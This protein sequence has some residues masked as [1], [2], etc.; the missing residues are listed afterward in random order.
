MSKS[1]LTP[2]LPLKNLIAGIP[3]VVS[4]DPNLTTFFKHIIL[5]DYGN[6]VELASNIVRDTMSDQYQL[7][8]SNRINNRIIRNM[9][10]TKFQILRKVLKDLECTE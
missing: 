2:N 6:C 8:V 10:T 5:F 4:N 1:L 3:V 7:Q 9:I